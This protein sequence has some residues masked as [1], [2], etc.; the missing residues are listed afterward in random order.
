[1]GFN[2]GIAFGS[3]LKNGVQTYAQLQQIQSAAMSLQQQQ[4]QMASEKAERDAAANGAAGT[5]TAVTPA[6]LASQMQGADGKADPDAVMSTY[7][8]TQDP[9]QAPSQTGATIQ[10]GI[11]QGQQANVAAGQGPQGIGVPVQPQVAAAPT[12]PVAAGGAPASFNQPSGTPVDAATQFIRSQEGGYVAN[13]NGKGPTNYGING[14]ANNLTPDQVKSLT[15]AQADAIYKTKYLNG[16]NGGVDVSGLPTATAVAVGDT[17]ANM[18]QQTAT[19]LFKESG[20]DLNKFLD[21]RQQAYDKINADPAT[22]QSWNSRMQALREYVDQHGTSETGATPP[23]APDT[24]VTLLHAEPIQAVGVGENVKFSHDENGN[25]QM[26]KADTPADAIQR[27]AT[28]AWQKGDMKNGPQLQTLAIQMRA[29]EAQQG[30]TKILTDDKMDADQKVAQLAKLAGVQAY[31]TENGGYVLPGLGPTDSAGNPMPMTLA[32]AGNLASNLA[33]PEGLSHVVDTQLALSK[34]ANSN[35][36]TDIKQQTANAAG[37]EAGAKAQ[38]AVADTALKGKQAEY[39]GSNADATNAAKNAQAD[40]RTAQA[41]IRRQQQDLQKQMAALD[42]KSPDYQANMQHLVAQSSMLSS[43]LTG[44]IPELPKSEKLD[45]NAPYMEP[46]GSI[47]RMVPG[48][49]KVPEA[50]APRISLGIQKMTSNPDAYK[51]IVQAGSDSTRKH[52]GFGISPTVAKNA[53]LDP[54]VMYPTPD[55]AIAAWRAAVHQP[56]GGIPATQPAPN[57]VVPAGIPVAGNPTAAIP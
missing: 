29:Q 30:V 37:V 43:R 15:P 6:T 52:W 8:A 33:T 38:E 13:D 55:A 7:G 14:Q 20:G 56:A 53:G 17:A 39:Y 19:K 18:G 4:T 57:A 1:M 42:P 49:G 32:A 50:D 47:V 12:A 40:E 25:V 21:L 10:Q 11:A 34:L 54:S 27:M 23:V 41:D 48:A 22:H 16:S 24:K 51:G 45:E 3:A 9:T 35:R 36:E 5:T 26:T 28:T 31:K 2:F 46:D 44:K